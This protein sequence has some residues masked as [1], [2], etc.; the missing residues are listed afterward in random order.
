MSDLTA[1]LVV[2]ILA[3]LAVQG[4]NDTV[5]EIEKK[6]FA[7]INDERK[8]NNRK[9]LVLNRSLALAARKQS[10]RM[11][12]D[13][14]FNHIDPSGKGPA[15]RVN[16]EGYRWSRV[17]ENIAM[18]SGYKDPISEAVSGWMNSPGHRRNILDGDF[19]ETGIGVARIG[20]RLYFTQVFA[21]PRS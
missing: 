21:R 4:K 12:K 16:E 18:N 9:P 14:F 6:V 17:G 2:G 7:A 10:E 13:R 15:E 5:D 20:K 19:T 1:G 8:K 11:V 3:M